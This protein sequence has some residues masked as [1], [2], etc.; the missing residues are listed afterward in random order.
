MLGA[1]MRSPAR[2]VTL[3]TR[4]Q[5]TSATN[6]RATGIRQMPFMLGAVTLLC[7]TGSILGG[8]ATELI[9]RQT[10]AQ[11]NAMVYA[12]AIASGSFHY[13]DHQTDLL[14]GYLVHETDAGDASLNEGIELS[15]GLLGDAEVIVVDSVAY[16][17]GNAVCLQLIGFSQKVANTYANRWI[18]VMPKD[19]PYQNL[20]YMVLT[21]TFWG[22]PRQAPM[23]PLPQKGLS[24]SGVTTLNGRRL[25]SVTSSIH[26]IVK[27]TNSSFIGSSRIYFATKAPYLPY[28]VISETRGTAAGSPTAES[29][30]AT[31]T[32]WGEAVRVI[33]PSGALPYSSLPPPTFGEH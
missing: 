25:L 13:V 30:S 10:P 20:V 21:K 28:A 1:Q 6:R 19:F 3:S 29:D 18:S 12:A 32:N 7:S 27:S 33:A 8:R 5:S 4:N 31:F 26:D 14:G 22:D 24:T 16:L 17:K 15:S 11:A 9:A 2:R 23:T